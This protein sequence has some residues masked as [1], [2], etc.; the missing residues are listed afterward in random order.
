M[1]HLSE[2]VNGILTNNLAWGKIIPMDNPKANDP[3]MRL[4]QH[5]DIT[6]KEFGSETATQP[7]H[8]T[9]YKRGRATIGPEPL[10]RIIDRFRREMAE[11]N[12]EYEDLQ[13]GTFNRPQQKRAR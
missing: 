7:T 4:L 11:C 10:K 12:V 3:L 9:S 1:S 5:L 8:V 2:R 6:D 13:R